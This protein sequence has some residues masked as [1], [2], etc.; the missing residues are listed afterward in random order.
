MLLGSTLSLTFP[1]HSLSYLIFLIMTIFILGLS[2]L[3]NQSNLLTTKFSFWYGYFF[4]LGSVIAFIGY[5]FSYYFR[6]QLNC[7]YFMSYAL[8]AVICLYTSLYIGVICYIYAKLKTKSNFFNLVIFFP[9][10]WV[11]TELIRGQFFPRSWYALGYTQV[12]NP[13]FHGYFP[14]L[15]VYFVSWL[16]V[17]ISGWFAY[18]CNELL[19]ILNNR[20]SF[21]PFR[22]LSRYI[23]VI[24][25][26]IVGFIAISMLLAQINYTKKY[27]KPITITLL[28]PSIFSSKNYNI[29]TLHELE[30]ISEQLIKQSNTD[31]IVLP[32]TVFGTY[33]KNL[34]EGYLDAINEYIEQHNQTLIFSTPLR[35]NNNVH[36]TGIVISNQLES[37]IYIKHHL[38]PFGEYN[39]IKGTFLELFISS[40]SNQISSNVAGNKHQEPTTI[41]GQR[42]AFNICYENTVNDYVASN[43]KSATILL[44]QSDL[45]WYGDT[46]MKDAFLQFSQE[47]GRAHV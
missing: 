39:P 40:F 44:N 14:L 21:K 34:T 20:E 25:L 41:L 26:S 27:G 47:I 46:N 32:E 1:P 4:Y 6:L 45:S 16:V 18:C 12:D 37:P 35:G 28:Q 22:V 2:L 13:V 5:W 33:Y 19:N 43:A 15:G 7:S 10:L 30:N 17:A 9:S 8:T 42:F 24:I 11:L 3:N 36:Q 23:A 29:N 31:L 38:V